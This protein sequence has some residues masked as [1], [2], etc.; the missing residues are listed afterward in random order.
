MS[1]WSVLVL[2]GVVLARG[3]SAIS[4]YDVV[5]DVDPAHIAEAP[6]AQHWLGTD[7]LGRDVLWRLVRATDA[8]VVPG[9]AAALLAVLGGTLLGAVAGWTGA[10]TERVTLAMAGLPGAVPR[11][12]LVLLLATI[13][14]PTPTVLAIGCGLA[15]LPACAAEVGSRVARLRRQDGVA[16][17]LVH[18]NSTLRVLAVHL[19]WA[20]CRPVYPRLGLEAWSFYLVVETTLSY[21]G[22][23]GVQEPNP[24]WGNMVQGCLVDSRLAWPAR[25]AAACCIAA[26]LSAAQHLGRHWGQR[27]EAW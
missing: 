26:T 18:G 23:L 13:F 27:E 9:L 25:V 4:G 21:L 19:L 20:Q 3:V 17:S 5:A 15:F 14:Q 24:S 10:T 22:D 1:R 12:V 7:A 16:A 6:S 11:F 8:F 2:A